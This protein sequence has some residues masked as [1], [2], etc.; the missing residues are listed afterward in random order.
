MEPVQHL[1]NSTAAQ[2]VWLKSVP[3]FFAHEG[4]LLTALADMRVPQLLAQDGGEF[5]LAKIAGDDLYEP[6]PPSASKW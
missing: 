6:L 5:L 2:T 4:R 3:P 1:A